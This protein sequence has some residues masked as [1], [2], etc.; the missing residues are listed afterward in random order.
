[1]ISGCYDAGDDVKIDAGISYSEAD[2]ATVIEILADG[3]EF[4]PFKADDDDVHLGVSMLRR[5]ARNITHEYMDGV[6][7]ISVVL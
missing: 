4:D 3:R 1:M 6:N 7:R 5:I 2:G